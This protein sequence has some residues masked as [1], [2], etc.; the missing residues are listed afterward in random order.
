MKRLALLAVFFALPNLGFSDNDGALAV[1][2]LST[3]KYVVEIWRSK[4]DSLY[5]VKAKRGAVLTGK[6]T[7]ME[8]ASTFPELGKLIEHGV[9]DHAIF[10]PLAAPAYSADKF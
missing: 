6:I 1:G 7:A 9:A 5:V 3:N 2:S 4:Q 8:L 10:Y